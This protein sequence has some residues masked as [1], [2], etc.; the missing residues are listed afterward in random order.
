MKRSYPANID[1]QIFYIDEDAFILLQNYL[2]ELRNTFSGEEAGEIVADIESR[3]RELFA[4]KIESGA[5]VIVLADVNTVIATMGRPEQLSEETGSEHS[6]QSA[7]AAAE[8][9]NEENDPFI[10]INL[11]RHR[12]LYRNMKDKVLGGVFGGLAAYLGWNANIMR[13]L[14]AVITCFTY[15]WPCTILYLVLWMIIPPAVSPRQILEMKGDPIN[16]GTVGQTVIDN[17]NT[18]VTPPPISGNENDFIGTFFNIAAKILMGFLGMVAGIIDLGLVVAFIVGLVGTIAY[19]FFANPFI[20][21][22]LHV[23]YYANVGIGIIMVLVWVLV[24]IIAMSALVWTS[25]CFV[26]NVRGASR[27]VVIS[28]LVL[29][30]ILIATGICLTIGLNY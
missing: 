23:P 7:P 6:E 18:G 21:E 13:L 8:A 30:L 15:F 11:P 16:V 14:F 1:G 5:A 22:G 29:E 19:F 26:S 2:Q 24:G 9:A 12:K 3:I 20:F 28:T 27:A 17:S 10:T 4:E 25:L